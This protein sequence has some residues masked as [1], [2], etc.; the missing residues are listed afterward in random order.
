MSSV[1]A[2]EPVVGP[3]D[4]TVTV[5]GSKSL[6]NRALVCAALADG[7]STIEGGLVAD[8]TEAMIEALRTLGA[9]IDETAE[10]LAVTGTGGRLVPGPKELDMRLSG[11]TSRFLLPVVA[12]GSGRYRADGRS[13]LRRRPMGP[14]LDGIR[15]LGASVSPEGEPGHLPVTI[16]APGG[17]PGGDVAVSGDTSSQYLSGLLLAAPYTRD[18]VRLR[19]TT[20]VVGRPFVDLTLA[21]MAAFGVDVEVTEPPGADLAPSGPSGGSAS[22]GGS[23][24]AGLELVVPAGRYRSVRYL[25]E[26]DASTASYLLAAA[27]ICGGRVTVDGLGRHSQQGDAGFAALLGAMGAHVERTASATTVTGTGELEG[28]GD[29]DLSTMPDMAQT[30]AAVAV[31]ANGPTRVRGVGF[32]RGHETDRVAAVVR[33]LRRCGIEADEEPD[34]FVVRPGTPRPAR[35]ATYDD[36]RM[37]MSFALL[38]LRRPGIEIEDPGCVAKTFPDFWDV[39]EGLRS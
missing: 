25:V 37:A 19:V 31:F 1:R 13:G 16:V 29:V 14:V 36:H 28:L 26:P 20:T 5:P 15:Q 11:T 6:T 17:L 38:G 12:L 18:G 32:I 39:L 24:A 10:T 22:S 9:G 8:D 7:I 3:I 4:A 30:L 27:A 34:G 23:S 2:I 33:E 21:V 35:I